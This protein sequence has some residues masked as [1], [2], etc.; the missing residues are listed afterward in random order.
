MES[1]HRSS[2]K[3]TAEPE[4]LAQ[5][6]EVIPDRRQMCTSVFAGGVMA[7]MLRAGES[8]TSGE[9]GTAGESG[10]VI[11]EVLQDIKTDKQCIMDA[12]LTEAE[13][14]CWEKTAQAAAAFFKLP[15]LHPED[16]KEVSVAIH[17]I[18]Q[19]LLGRPTYRKYLEIAKAN[20]K[21]KKQ[22]AQK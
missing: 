3:P 17:V 10:T 5:N 21:R 11:Q 22:A 6:H 16:A 13:A 15:V 1:K 20:H 2:S 14:D 7:A 8:G 12:G 4:T 19:K 9:S 18:Q